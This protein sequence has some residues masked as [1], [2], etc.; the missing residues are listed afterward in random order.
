MRVHTQPAAP[1]WT[2]FPAPPHP[3]E[4][5]PPSYRKGPP[6]RLHSHQPGTPREGAPGSSPPQW[7]RRVLELP[8]LWFS[9]P[10]SAPRQQGWGRGGRGR[11]SLVPISPASPHPRL[12]GPSL[13]VF[14][15]SFCFS[16][17]LGNLCF[18]K[19]MSIKQLYTPSLVIHIPRVL[20]PDTSY[21]ILDHVPELS[22]ALC[23][24][25]SPSPAASHP[26]GELQAQRVSP[27]PHTWA[28]PRTPPRPDDPSCPCFPPPPRPAAAPESTVSRPIPAFPSMESQPVA[29]RQ[30]PP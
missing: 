5:A 11:R 4:G 28:P 9:V 17:I 26:H 3:Q 23:D 30:W 16:T 14:W 15:S 18:E 20:F 29:E 6:A 2:T 1:P 12:G 10:R 21:Y 24:C 27:P 13:D 7:G 19:V 8:V 25:H 22:S